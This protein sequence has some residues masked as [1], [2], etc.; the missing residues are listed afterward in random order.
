ML[1]ILIILSLIGTIY[2]IAS[3]V[4]PKVNP[5]NK[6]PAGGKVLIF[7]LIGLILFSIV[8]MTLYKITAQEVGVVITPKG[9]QHT[10][11]TTGWNFVAPWSNVKRMDKTVWVYTLVSK[12]KEGAKVEDDAI[13]APTA[14]GI[15]M[16]FDISVNWRINPDEAA[17]VY[18]N[19]VSDQ[20]IDGRYHWIEDNI[21]RPAIKSVMAQTVSNF[22]PI[23]CYSDKRIVIQEKVQAVLK[24][25]LTTNRLIVD[26]VQIREVHYSPQYEASIN[27]KKL[28]EQKVL[29][30]VQIT[31]QQEE[32]LKQATINKNIAIEKAEGE[33]KSLLIKGEAINKNPQIISLEWIAKWDGV[34]PIYQMGGG[35][36]PNVLISMPTKK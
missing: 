36:T 28:A 5:E 12:S 31:R 9:V 15:K 20:A 21:I 7:S 30:L 34:L 33:A 22:T 10:P 35:S 3:I 4:L 18:S 23:E 19:I 1:T 8:S 2:G 6:L 11:I 17:W 13:W 25:E 26:V 29:T 16:G 14:D 27:E 24:K 32:L